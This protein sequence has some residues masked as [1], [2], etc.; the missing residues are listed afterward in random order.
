MDLWLLFFFVVSN[1]LFLSPAPCPTPS[2]LHPT[3][4]PPSHARSGLFVGRPFHLLAEYCPFSAATQ[5]HGQ[6]QQCFSCRR[7]G[8]AQQGGGWEGGVG[9]GRGVGGS[10]ELFTNEET[11]HKCFS[12]LLPGSYL[13]NTDPLCCHT[14]GDLWLQKKKRKK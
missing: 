10:V 13:I 5:P 8:T 6:G 11:Q 14:K 12:H 1:A 4:P 3:P 2:P 7:S 9:G